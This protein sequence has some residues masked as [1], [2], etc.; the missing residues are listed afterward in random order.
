MSEKISDKEKKRIRNLMKDGTAAI[1]EE[2]KSGKPYTLTRT[3][4]CTKRAYRPSE[5]ET[6]SK[7]SV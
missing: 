4:A 5:P 7:D 1:I 6:N 3:L 2:A